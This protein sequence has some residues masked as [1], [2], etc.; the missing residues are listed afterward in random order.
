MEQIG[1]ATVA[2]LVARMLEAIKT[3]Q[4]PSPS[5]EDGWRA[6]LVLDAVAEA[7]ARGGWIDVN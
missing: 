6:Q 5:L 4:T 2:P 7:A 3:G 1:R